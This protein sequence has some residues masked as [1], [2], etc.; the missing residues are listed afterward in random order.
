[1]FKSDRANRNTTVGTKEPYVRSG[2]IQSTKMLEFQLPE[3]PAGV[4]PVS[5]R[6][7]RWKAVAVCREIR[8][9]SGA[10]HAEPLPVLD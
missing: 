5:S 9:D 7:D 6:K 2:A 3:A 1:M 4:G 10:L 8:N